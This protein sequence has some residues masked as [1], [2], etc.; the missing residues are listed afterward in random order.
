MADTAQV[1]PEEVERWLA[2]YLTPKTRLVQEAMLWLKSFL[3]K[4]Y[5]VSIMCNILLNG[6][7]EQVCIYLLLKHQHNNA[8]GQRQ[9]LFLNPARLFDE[10]PILPGLPSYIPRHQLGKNLRG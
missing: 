3:K 6:H 8:A 10:K 1:G 4:P 7:T 5:S 2:Q 9:T